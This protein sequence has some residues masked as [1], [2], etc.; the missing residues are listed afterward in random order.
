MLSHGLRWAR[1]SVAAILSACVVVGAEASQTV[2]VG[3]STTL[4]GLARRYDVP[5]KAIADANNISVEAV[6]VDGRRL[7]I[8]DPPPLVRVPATMSV[9]G[10]IVGN[11]VA[12]RRGPGT[13][14]LRVTLL[15]DGAKLTA[16]AR[17]GEWLQVQGPSVANAWIRQ[18][19]VSLSAGAALS[20]LVPKASAAVVS[21]PRP[22]IAAKPAAKP[23]VSTASGLRCIKGDRIALRE[24]PD[25]GSKRLALMDDGTLLRLLAKGNGWCKVRVSDGPTGWVLGSF[26]SDRSRVGRT[27]SQ[28]LAA[29]QADERRARTASSTTRRARTASSSPQRSGR[30]ARH[31]RPEPAAPRSGSDVVRTA[32]A[33]RGTRYRYGGSARG[34]FDCSGFTRY[35]YGSKGV[36][37]PHNAAAQF[38]KGQRVSRG[39]LKAG[40]LVFFH[41]TRRSISHVGIYVGSGKFVHASS[42]RGRVRVDSLNS[43]YYNNRFRGARRVK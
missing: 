24:K 14:F 6:L 1:I 12:L 30:F 35:V 37:L 20:A 19:F 4:D 23:G 29:R 5:K 11:R 8:P 36:A 16:T 26:V 41:T 9:T 18:D 43:G 3:P 10:K 15:D 38:S 42:A 7:V 25:T 33:Y 40:D 32:Y 21:Q 17:K 28:I 13:E 31:S 39:N 34:G 2:V 27:A 22:A